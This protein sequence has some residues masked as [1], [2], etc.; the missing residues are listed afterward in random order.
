MYIRCRPLMLLSSS[1]GI[2]IAASGGIAK[3]IIE[4]NQASSQTQSLALRSFSQ[5]Q[6]FHPAFAT[7]CCDRG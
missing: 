3:T 2:V 1:H 6:D 4:Y 7:Q 5:P